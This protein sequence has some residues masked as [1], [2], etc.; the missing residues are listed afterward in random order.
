MYTSVNLYRLECS[1]WLGIL[2]KIKIE[3]KKKERKEIR[4]MLITVIFLETISQTGL[5]AM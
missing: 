5:Q 2:S 3:S 1:F 4:A